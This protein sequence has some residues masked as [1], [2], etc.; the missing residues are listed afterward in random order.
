MRVQTCIYRR[1]TLLTNIRSLQQTALHFKIIAICYMGQ[2][3]K[4]LLKQMFTWH[5][6]V[7]EEGSIRL[8][9][10]RRPWFLLARYRELTCRVCRLS[11]R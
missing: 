3:E 8:S 4:Q 2:N 6:L 10:L 11:E 7:N 1:I 9:H 5:A